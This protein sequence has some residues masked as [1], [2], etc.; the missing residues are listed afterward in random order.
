MQ[1]QAGALHLSTARAEPAVARVVQFS[2]S[3]TNEVA[4]VVDRAIVD[5]EVKDL[6]LE[7]HLD[8]TDLVWVASALIDSRVS[9]QILP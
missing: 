5:V 1:I 2:T 3:G 7:A 6:K 8:N 4:V 9:F